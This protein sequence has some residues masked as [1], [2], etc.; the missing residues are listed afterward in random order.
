MAGKCQGATK[1]VSQRGAGPILLQPS[2]AKSPIGDLPF[3]WRVQSARRGWCWGGKLR[4]LEHRLRLR[5]GVA[6]VLRVSHLPLDP[7]QSLQQL[8]GGRSCA[9]AR[10]LGSQSAR[11]QP[12][13]HEDGGDPCKNH[14]A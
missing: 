11:P 2:K 13:R 12:G 14:D 10:L 3:E 1:H 5:G 4:L 7:G 9:E 6:R 8:G